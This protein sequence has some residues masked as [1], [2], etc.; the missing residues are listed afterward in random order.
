MMVTTPTTNLLKGRI[1]DAIHRN[2]PEMTTAS[3]NEIKV[4]AY[5]M[6]Q[7]N[8][9][10][11]LKKFGKGGKTGAVKELT[12]L[13]MMDTWTAVDPTKLSREQQ[14]KALLSL[15]FLKEKRM[16]DVK[17]RACING[18]PQQA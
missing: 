10:P 13:H 3:E 15:L 9:K 8:L 1:D 17:R 18:A 11:G 4:W 2:D 14:M 12:Q 6:T 7:Y 16:G 5:L